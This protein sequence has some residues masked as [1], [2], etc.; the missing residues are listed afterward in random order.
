MHVI[1]IVAFVAAFIALGVYAWYAAEQR[2]KALAAWGQANGLT[3]S[4]DRLY[5][6]DDR[7]PD[8]DC[9][10][11]GSN[12]YAY[13][14]LR[15]AYKNWP[16]TAFDY[17]YETHSTNSKGRRQTHHHHFSAA[18][19][20]SPV[21]L[22]PLSIRPEGLFDKVTEFLG[23]EDIDFESAEFSRKFYVKAPDRKW[24][25]D[26]LHPRAMEFMLSMPVFALN[27]AGASVLVCRRSVFKPEEFAQALD[28]ATGLLERLPDYV[29]N[30]LQ[31]EAPRGA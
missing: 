4:A 25:Y 26:V 30:Q 6:L 2:R 17:H 27:F 13:N 3:F 18:I 21:P 29:V 24:A 19:I 20:D 22:K 5:G 23:M 15:G 8:F 9:L 14:T 1:L 7:H 10:R 16:C 28:L 11:S 12:R 31:S